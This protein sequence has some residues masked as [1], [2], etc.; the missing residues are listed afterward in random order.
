MDRTPKNKYDFI[1]DLLETQKLN[2]AQKER[3]LKL[4]SK[5][6]NNT[7]SS[8]S[9]I[10]ERLKIIEEKLGF[11]EPD[12]IDDK[13]EDQN[14]T[15]S[16]TAN[17]PP[18]YFNPSELY[19]YLF[20]YNQNSILK[21]TCHE[22]DSDELESIIEYCGTKEYVFEKH[23]EKIIEA[24]DQHNKKYFA[25]GKLTSFIRGYLTGKDYYG[26]PLSEGWS[27]NKISFSWS[28]PELKDW[29]INNKNV[30]PNIDEGLM[31]RIENTGYE[32][33]KPVLLRNGDLISGF[34]DL[35]IH[36]KKQFHIR[37]DNSLRNIIIRE[38]E[39]K[40]WDNQIDFDITPEGFPDRVEFFTNVDKLVNA[41]NGVIKLILEQNE[42]NKP[43]VKLTLIEGPSGITFSIL[44]KNSLFGKS[45]RNL[46]DRPGQTYANLIRLHLNGLC[47]FYVNADFEN[48][49]S[50]LIELWA[51]P[52]LWIKE[53]PNATKLTIPVGGVEHI[54]EFIKS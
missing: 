5:E 31:N 6:L 4:A 41:Y 42:T 13:I 24:F 35:V 38:N 20:A 12:I 47:N 36:F 34:N 53:R 48:D 28:S 7:D 1:T 30:P 9:E 43:E 26:K 32:L 49:G 16:D 29:S 22:I 8:T 52:G 37:R 10:E 44:H 18:N 15:T 19:K 50:Y 45:V 25:Q 17:I 11:S 46:T 27:S 54:F 21:S 2:V 23:L 39:T 51:R 3:I 33:G 40:K 14:S